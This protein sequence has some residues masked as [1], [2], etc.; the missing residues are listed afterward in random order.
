MAI[1]EFVTMNS[2]EALQKIQQA[3][4]EKKLTS[5][6]ADN[7]DA[8]L[9]QSRYATYAD[10]ILRH[11]EQHDWQVLDDVFW[12]VIPFGT[13]GR[14]GRMF[15][16]GSNAINERTIG[17]S[18]QGLA[19]YVK[20]QSAA[21]TS[22]ACAI[23][24]DTRHN[25]IAFARLCAEVMV[26][27][28]FKVYFLDD[29]RSTPELSFLVRN[30]QCSCGIMVTASHNPPSDN[31]VKCYWST[32]G[33][34]LPPHDQGVIEQVMNVGEI[35]RADFDAALADGRIEI[36]TA[37]TDQAF[38]AAVSQQAFPGPRE[39][40][41]IYSPLHG[42]GSSA[43]LPALAADS[44]PNVQVFG[45]HE[46]PNGDFPNVPNHVSNP[47]NAA[48]FDAIIQQ[49][50]RDHADLI[51]ATDPDCDRLGCAAPLAASTGTWRTFSGNQIAALLADY[52]LEQRETGWHNYTGPLRRQDFGH[53]RPR[54]SN[55]RFVRRSNDWRFASGLQVDRWRDRPGGPDRFVFG[56]EESHGYLVGQYARDKDAAVAAMLLAELAALVKSQNK[57]LNDKLDDL[58]WQHGY[59]AESL[60]NQTMPGSEGM[61]RMKQLMAELRESPPEQ[62]AGLDVATVRD[63]ENG[64]RRFAGGKTQPL[65]GPKGDLV[66]L[67]LESPGNY[68]A[69][70]PSGTEP[71]VKYYVFTFVPA[72]QLADLEV[73]KR[74]MHERI[75]AIESDLNQ[76]A[77][78]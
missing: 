33:Q 32:G 69:V 52:I 24:Y 22:L 67:D 23:A 62:L 26:A 64:V 70:R 46:E 57:S 44:F 14:R 49:A 72:E 11:I 21:R 41:I 43:V 37:E 13:G 36:C 34:I 60:I 6:A 4:A 71:K 40:R 56:A 30:K 55:C 25:S 77:G 31:A 51:L 19:T 42:V 68:V 35:T 74:Q 54:P 3:V 58:Y 66:M 28:G 50:Q 18:A 73:A 20:T 27:A 63:F 76:L 8:W 38:V 61:A 39:I 7:I 1:G 10:Q 75:V 16:I 65:S 29:Y 2:N 45:P 17:E 12:T 9:T 15:P 53:Y 5:T 48:V 59:H 47:E 78:C